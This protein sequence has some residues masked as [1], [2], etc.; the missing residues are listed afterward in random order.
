[1]ITCRDCRKEKPATEF[2]IRAGNPTNWCRLCKRTYDANYH[3]TRAPEVKALKLDKMKIRQLDLKQKLWD[4]KTSHP[5]IDCAESDPIVLEFDHRDSNTKE[6]DIC[7]MVAAK[8]SWA[9]IVREIEKCDVR[10]A[11]CHRRR[12]HKQFGWFIGY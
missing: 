8:F 11:N 10:C 6:N 2:T 9:A 12:T 5:C 4:Y 1:M 3:K 7:R